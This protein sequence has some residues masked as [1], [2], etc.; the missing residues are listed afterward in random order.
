MTMLRH[1]VWLALFCVSCAT[2]PG[3]RT[4]FGFAIGISNAPPPP[5]V[6]YVEEPTVVLVPR[7]RVYVV[8]EVDYDMFRYGSY[9]YV[10][11]G[12]Y[13]YRARSHAGPFTVCDVRRVPRQILTL[14]PE[15]WKR[16]PHGGPPGR[17]KKGDRDD[18]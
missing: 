7:T 10:S 14:P 16:H 3:T 17:M 8:Q 18:D 4:H 13:W 11:S 5:R 9:W 6:V 1:S 2:A 12:G 15:R